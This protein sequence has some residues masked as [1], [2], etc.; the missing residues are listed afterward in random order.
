MGTLSSPGLKPPF[1]PP[2][3]SWP[4]TAVSAGAE[5]RGVPA[6]TARLCWAV[7][8]VGVREIRSSRF[9]LFPCTSAGS[10]AQSAAA[11]PPAAAWECFFRGGELAYSIAYCFP[12]ATINSRPGDMCRHYL[13][14]SNRFP[15]DSKAQLWRRRAAVR[16]AGEVVVGVSSPR[17]LGPW[18][19]GGEHTLSLTDL[20]HIHTH[21]LPGD[22]SE[23]NKCTL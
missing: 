8:A 13:A 10:G 3:S 5:R 6:H 23:K 22:P 11:H 19:H 9:S 1:A 12:P 14:V 21:T 15:G 4:A 20:D 16:A 17:F 18:E 7:K 2:G